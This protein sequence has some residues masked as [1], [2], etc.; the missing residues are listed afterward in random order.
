MAPRDKSPSGVTV[1]ARLRLHQEILLEFARLAIDAQDLSRLLD[2]GA[3]QIARA[4]GVHHSKILRYEADAAGLKMLA[5]RG[6]NPGIVGHAVLPIDMRSP[7]GRSYQT[8]APVR[9]PD[10][11][12]SQELRYEP[13]LREHGIRALI[14][15]PIAIDGIVWGVAELDST[16][17]DAF[18]R[19]DER[20]L[21]AFAHI[22]ALAVRGRETERK[23]TA[24][25][26]DASAQLIRSQSMRDEQ[27]HRVRNYFQ[28]ILGLLGTRSTHA[29]DPTVRKEFHAVMERIAA[30][31]LAHDM[32]E[33][34][35]GAGTIDTGRY[36]N[37]LCDSMER[38]LGSGPKI[39]RKIESLP[40]RSDRIV[41][42]G[43]ILNELLTNCIKYA[44]ID[45]ADRH[46]EVRFTV[47]HARHEGYLV[48]EDNGPGMG[49][50]RKNSKGL[51]FVE[52]LAA[53]L[54][55]SVGIENR[56]PG[57]RVRICLPIID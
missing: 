39:L 32:L 13:L 19:D 27:S 11:A 25:L 7:A 3:E 31:S 47:D 22:L 4:T 24:A 21:Q 26:K 17:P 57:T 43:L 37:A 2:I 38:I 46:I 8:R 33:I 5:G 40:L 56:N 14:N 6:W 53:Q 30:I 51:T 12:N 23:R 35:N 20:F 16:T 48:V 34:Q 36:L 18:S 9:D 42:L 55:G 41:P 29:A 49:P 44:R 52:G 10:V 1:A 28:M 50:R 15:A 45:R 54:S